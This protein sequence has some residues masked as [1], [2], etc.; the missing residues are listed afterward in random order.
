MS[1]HDLLRE[2]RSV[3]VAVAPFA[4]VEVRKRSCAEGSKER[5][6]LSC[7]RR[8]VALDHSRALGRTGFAVTRD[9]A[10]G[11]A[12]RPLADCSRHQRNTTGPHASS[13]K[14]GKRSVRRESFDSRA[15]SAR[16]LPCSH[17][18]STGSSGSRIIARLPFLPGYRKSGS[19]RSG[20]T[21]ARH[22]TARASPNPRTFHGILEHVVEP[23]NLAAWP[24]EQMSNCSRERRYRGRATPEVHVDLDLIPGS[25][26]GVGRDP[27]ELIDM[28][29]LRIG[30]RGIQCRGTQREQ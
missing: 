24:V 16:D 8:L 26:V 19:H 7:F 25:A 29:N 9:H 28:H 23:I 27:S 5:L 12:G 3:A 18:G 15:R 11:A 2:L 17:S 22:L 14:Y 21:I 10:Y 13:P 30:D 6:C 4:P 1:K 20:Y